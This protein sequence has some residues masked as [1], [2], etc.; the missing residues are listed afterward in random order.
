MYKTAQKLKEK[1][2]EF[3]R[4]FGIERNIFQK[5]VIVYKYIR[6]LH[7]DPLAKNILQKIFDETVKSVGMRN[8]DCFD[9]DEFLDVRGKAIFSKEFWQY[10]SNLETI[11]DNMKNMR[12]CQICDK[13]QYTKLKKLFSKPYSKKMF[14]LSF[15][16]INSEMFERLDQECFFSKK[17]D[18]TWF[19]EKR[20][21]LHIKEMLIKIVKQDKITNSHKILRYI[22]ITNKKNLNDEF[23][24]SE[25]AEIEFGD[26]DYNENLKA[27][28]RYRD[29]CKYTNKLILKQTNN[30]VG[31][32]LIFNTGQ[33][34]RVKLNRDF[35]A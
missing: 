15:E 16:V 26:L 27:W 6:L 23:F 2:S 12:D 3:T 29:A 32:F 30:K 14:S 21:I 18:R 7:R 9:E 4:L 13:K 8:A 11:H 22:F 19:D 20:S 34:G 25:I 17:Q 33:Q 35:I 1:M 28:E 31:N 24:Y 10:Y 5:L